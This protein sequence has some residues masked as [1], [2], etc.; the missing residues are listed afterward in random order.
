MH[1]HL[2]VFNVRDQRIA[3]VEW[4][5]LCGQRGWPAL[6]MDRR[7]RYRPAEIAAIRR[8]RVRVFALASG[9]LTVEEQAARFIRNRRRIELACETGGPLV[10]AVHAS[11]IVRVFPA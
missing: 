7:I 4:L 3:D 10:Y 1:T 9:N 8:H 2:E 11:E 5:E 6:T